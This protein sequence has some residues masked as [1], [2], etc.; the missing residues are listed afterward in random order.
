MNE[1][2]S[3]HQ[4]KGLPYLSYAAGAALGMW[5]WFSLEH[6]TNYRI[7]HGG[8]AKAEPI[9]IAFPLIASVLAPIIAL[10]MWRRAIGIAKHGVPVTATVRSISSVVKQ[11]RNVSFEYEFQGVKYS[12]RKS[13]DCTCSDE[14]TLGG[15]MEIIVDQRNPKRI[16]L[17]N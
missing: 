11:M 13:I 6:F 16:L 9:H 8:E 5:G 10:V 3:V 1:P 17:K 4:V 14:L 12:K 7:S 15:E 2:D